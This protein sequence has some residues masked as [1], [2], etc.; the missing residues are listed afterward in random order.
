M[1]AARIE[2]ALEDRRPEEARVDLRGRQQ[3]RQLQGD[4]L[5]AG[6]GGEP[7]LGDGA[8]LLGRMDSVIGP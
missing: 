5:G 7:V 8:W 3:P 1:D 4:A 2:G 6:L